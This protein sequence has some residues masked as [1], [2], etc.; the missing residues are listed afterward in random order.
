MGKNMNTL[1]ITE[2]FVS[3]QGEG[4]FVGFPAIFLRLAGCIAPYCSFCDSPY[5]LKP[6]KDVDVLK[7][8]KEIS[9]FQTKLVVIT[10]GEPFLQWNRG[11]NKLEDILTENGFEIQ[12]ETSGKVLI[13]PSNNNRY[14]VC[15]PKQNGNFQSKKWTFV[16]E[17][18]NIADCYKFIYDDNEQI[19]KDFI[20]TYEIP[21]DKVYLMAEGVDRKTQ[22]QKMEETWD[23]CVANNWKYSPRLHI[24]AFDQKLGV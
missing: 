4:P 9:S 22:M 11:L 12:Y 2:L 15:S 16:E 24:L 23:I 3:L 1:N 17:N 10:G 18:R 6:G 8:A 13:P 21:T 7:L 19:I 14:I 5:S 20:E